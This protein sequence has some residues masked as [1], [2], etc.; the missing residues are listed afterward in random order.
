MRSYTHTFRSVKMTRTASGPCPV[1]GKRVRRSRTFES[2]INP[3]NRNDDGTV[4]TAPEVREQV[5]AKADE[6]AP[7]FRHAGCTERADR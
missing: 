5:Q 2:T 3:F 4:K 7:D 1:C 6:W